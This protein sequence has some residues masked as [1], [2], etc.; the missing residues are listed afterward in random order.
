MGYSIAVVVLLLVHVCRSGRIV[1]EIGEKCQTPNLEAGECRNIKNCPVLLEYVRQSVAP[2]STFLRDSNCGFEGLDALVCCPELSSRLTPWENGGTNRNRS[3]STTR[4][5]SSNSPSRI[6]GNECGRSN[7]QIDRIVGGTT[8]ALGAWPWVA[9]LGYRSRTRSDLQWLCGGALVTNRHI[10]T[11]GHCVIIPST[12][13]L[14]VARLGDINL[15]DNVS[16]GASPVDMQVDRTIPHP[17][18]RTNAK[19]N[20]IAI[21]KLRSA[22]QFSDHI[23]PICLP[24]SSLLRSNTFV[25]QTPYVAGWGA[26]FFRGPST[27]SL[28]QVDIDITDEESCKNAYRNERGAVIDNRVLCAG[29]AG[30]DACQG[31]SGG[32]L[33]LDQG[34]VYYLIGVVSYGKKCAEPGYPGVYTRV[35]SFV[36]WI[37]RNLD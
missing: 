37:N 22:V 24:S 29:K 33:M 26:L 1:R 12:M 7:L 8:V 5:P 6:S 2:T 27:K 35:T 16:D 15:D 30:K 23:Q 19:V 18:Y 21:V 25:G 28:Q 9:A 14:S 3:T 11:A 20:D 4:R 17:E 32:P 10:V 36:D 13:T 31:D 34:A